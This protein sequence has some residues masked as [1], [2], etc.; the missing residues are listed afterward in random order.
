MSSP[1][2]KIQT[3][4]RK[5]K[6]NNKSKKQECKIQ[7][8]YNLSIDSNELETLYMFSTHSCTKHIYK[9]TRDDTNLV[10]ESGVIRSDPI[11]IRCTN[12]TNK[13]SV[14]LPVNTSNNI[15]EY[16]ESNMHKG[17]LCNVYNAELCDE[18]W[19]IFI[20]SI[21]MIYNTFIT[22]E[23]LKIK[24]LHINDAPGSVLSALNHFLYNSSIK[25]DYNI[26]WKWLSTIPLN[27][28]SNSPNSFKVGTLINKAKQKYT[29]N[30]LNLIER[31][32]Y[33]INNINFIINETTSKLQKINLLI[34]NTNTN[35]NMA[36]LSYAALIIKLMETNSIF[37]IKIPNITE[38]D[39]QFI[40]ILLLYSLLYNEIYV[41]KYNLTT[42]ST[43]L[44]CKNKKKINN[45]VIF[46]KIIHILSNK[47]FND[48][49][50]LFIKEIF[51]IP[52][53]NKWLRNILYVISSYD[54]TFDYIPFTDILN[55]LDAILDINM[56]T[57]Y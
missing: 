44:L 36:Y 7:H 27:K 9:L 11:S 21:N 35:T 17:Y 41:F 2:I 45:D 52:S 47:E 26:E 14:S 48:G 12:Y 16:I 42:Q 37:Y 56:T 34:I 33:S 49:Y 39:T 6:T 19:I 54:E 28:P 40:N 50:N 46:K 20:Y 22:N 43:Y 31:H 15:S 53:I 30:L 51:D 10:S 32:I 18:E 57:F 23:R 55:S 3:L 4:L 24:S 1:G 29:F 8:S 25:D 38:W 13:Q 5:F